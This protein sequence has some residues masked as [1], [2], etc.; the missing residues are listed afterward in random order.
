MKKD[1]FWSIDKLLPPI[2]LSSDFSLAKGSVSLNS[3]DFSLP[4][5]KWGE[6]V[7]PPNSRVIRSYRLTKVVEPRDLTLLEDFSDSESERPPF[8]PCTIYSPSMRMLTREMRR[9]F[10]YFYRCIRNR[11]KVQAS[12]AYL[13]LA[14]CRMV[15]EAYSKQEIPKDFYWL[16]ETYRND[17]PLADKLFSDVTSDFSFLLQKKPNWDRI[18]PILTQNNFTARSFLLDPYLFDH[19]FRDEYTMNPKEADFV[20]RKLTN[21]SFRNSKAYRMNSLFANTA[22]DAVQRAF[23]GGLFNRKDLNETLFAIQIPSEVRI[24]RQLFQGLPQEE[25]P[26]AEIQLLHVPLFHDENIRSRCDEILRY[27]ENRIRSILKMKNCL[28]RVHISP[29]HKDFLDGILLQYEHLRPQEESAP[30]SSRK[31][32]KEEPKPHQRPICIEASLA[33]EI[34]SR[35]WEITRTLTEIY[36]NGEEESVLL[37]GSEEE[38]LSEKYEN[39]LKLTLQHKPLDGNEFWEFAALLTEEEETFMRTSLSFGTDAAR[40]YAQSTGNFF[41]SLVLQCNQ[42]ASETVEDAVFDANGQIYTEYLNDLKEVFP[43]MEGDSQWIKK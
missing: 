14:L 8:V 9:Y 7:S 33:T 34:E 11:T 1:D 32:P 6:I 29:K 41:E 15:R 38:S 4:E 10:Y 27:L 16:W 18:S 21:L 42:K 25:I 17:F 13:L 37:G 22:E 19:L 12:Y 36:E 28:S 40:R 24:I 2:R 39:Q 5:K 3:L 43:P 31:C 23:R 35:S 20:L 30:V 26:S